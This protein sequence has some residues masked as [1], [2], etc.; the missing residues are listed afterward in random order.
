MSLDKDMKVLLVED[1][2]MTRKL[3]AK[4][5]EKIGYSNIIEAEDGDDAVEKLQQHPDVGL[6]I[7]DWNMP[8]KSGFELLQWVRANDPYTKVPFIMATARGEKKQ[9]DMAKEAGVSCFVIKPFGP[10]ELQAAI[11]EACTGKKKEAPKKVKPKKTASGKVHLDVAHIQ[12]TDHIILGVLKNFIAKGRFTP[13]HFELSTQCMPGW[14][15][16]QQGIESGEVDAAFMLAPIAMDLFGGN[17]P[18]KLVLYAHKNGSIVV[19]KKVGG[20]DESLKDFFDGKTFYIPHILSIHHMLTNMFLRQL[21]LTPGLAG[22]KDVNTFFEVIPPVQMPEFLKSNADAGGF[23]VAEPLGTKTIA[24][25]SAELLFLTGEL[26]EYHPCCVVVMRE[27]FVKANPAAAQEF[28]SM[29]VECGQ[30]VAEKPEI[31]AEIGV[32]F[33]DPEK[34]LGLNTSVLKNVLLEQQGIKTDDL[35]PSTADL[36]RIQRYMVEKMGIG[37][38]IDL[39]NFVDPRFADKAYE[40]SSATRRPSKVHDLGHV[41]RAVSERIAGEGSVKSNLDREG[42][43]LLFKLNNQEYGFQIL[44]VREILGMMPVRTIPSSPAH[45]KGV[46]NLRGKVI[47]L[48][49]LRMQMGMDERE[50]DAQTCIIVLENFEMTGPSSMGF[51]VDAVSEVKNI[52][53]DEI[54]DTPSFGTDVDTEFISAMARLD[55]GVKTLLNDRRLFSDEELASAI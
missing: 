13:Q 23:A 40:Q 12:I 26:W 45:I 3:E 54:V 43:Y 28:V 17:V 7:S 29:L 5:L 36:D 39:N 9:T 37:S 19:R 44:S 42:K 48:V 46:I 8:N 10:P 30:F 18:I 38:L 47:P 1:S 20:K 41:V 14:N 4:V 11:D 34:K 25:G 16:V 32:D 51:I 52:L 31:A 21:G 50:Y 53:A 33:L 15:P 2:G 35:Y 22:E 55:T 49:D 24:S 6:V 27:G